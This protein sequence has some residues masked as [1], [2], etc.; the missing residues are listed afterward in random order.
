MNRRPNPV[1]LALGV[2]GWLGL[3]WLGWTMWTA[4]PRTAGFDLE[5]VLQAGRDVAAGRSPYDP[6]MVG[7]AAPGST[8]LFYSYPPPVAQFFSLFAGVPSGVMFAALCVASGAGLAVAAALITRRFAPDRSA[9]AVVVPS[10]A[11]A[12]LFLP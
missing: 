11:I 2:V 6:A 5:L 12:R 10:V 3:I 4:T 7:G 9:S 8:D 1:V